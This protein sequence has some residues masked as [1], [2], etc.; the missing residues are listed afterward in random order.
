MMDPR[1][2]PRRASSGPVSGPTGWTVAASRR[3]A[4]IIGGRDSIAATTPTTSAD[5][6]EASTATSADSDQAT[7]RSGGHERSDRPIAGPARRGFRSGAGT[8]AVISPVGLL[9]YREQSSQVGDGQ[10]GPVAKRFFEHLTAI[11]Y[12]RE[13]DPFGWVETV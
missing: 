3:Q 12:G 9:H 11:Q 8:A 6:P 5:V 4:S 13:N 2:H 1:R 7:T 10:T